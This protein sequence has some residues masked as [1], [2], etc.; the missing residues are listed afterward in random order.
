MRIFVSRNIIHVHL[1][2]LGK[3]YDS[4]NEHVS[5][6][7][8]HSKQSQHSPS[9]EWMNFS[10]TYMICDHRHPNQLLAHMVTRVRESSSK[11]TGMCTSSNLWQWNDLPFEVHWNMASVPLG[12]YTLS[13]VTALMIQELGKCYSDVS[14][15][16]VRNIVPF[17]A[18]RIMLLD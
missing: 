1:N 2:T 15:A 11:I 10:T 6:Y 4:K 8:A 17:I 12:L 3:S 16:T 14:S 9:L 18:V 5:K 7:I 13:I